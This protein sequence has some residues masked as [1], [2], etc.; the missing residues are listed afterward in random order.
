MMT[1]LDPNT[2]GRA[3]LRSRFSKIRTPRG[4]IVVIPQA[5]PAYLD[6]TVEENLNIYSKLYD[7]PRREKSLYR[8]FVWAWVDLTNGARRPTTTLLRVHARRLEIAR[9][10]CSSQ[11]LF[12]R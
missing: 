8:R 12:P 7:V 6:L 10:W 4:D 2:A 9:G 5:R 3:R 1:T 11:N